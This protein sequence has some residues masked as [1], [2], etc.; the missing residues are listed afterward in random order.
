[1]FTNSKHEK[2]Y[3]ALKQGDIDG[4]ILLFT[5]A[6][7]AAPDDCDILSDR[8]VAF[9][10]KK[11]QL[12]C[13]ADFS[14]AISLDPNY[15]YRYAARAFARQSFG[16]FDG[17]V[18]DYKKAVELDPEDSVAHNN[19]GLLYEQQGY[20]KEAQHRFELADKLTKM[21]N[22]L[23]DVM[24]GLEAQESNK[25]S[26]EQLE[27]SEPPTIEPAPAEPLVNSEKT[28][29]P[30]AEEERKTSSKELKK[31]FTSRQQFREFIQ[32]IRNGFKIK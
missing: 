9:L 22:Q 7:L 16:D 4:A 10:H 3:E 17:A 12:R 11:D 29:E 21:E 8:G 18:E 25:Q 6:L 2:A 20:Q 26:T 27:K 1:M 30:M 13:L 19:L 23:Y 28:S 15:S 31:V 14:K 5:E 24:D 32:F